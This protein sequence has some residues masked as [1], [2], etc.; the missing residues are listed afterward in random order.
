[1]RSLFL[2]SLVG[3]IHSSSALKILLTNEDGIEHQGLQILRKALIEKGHS[4]STFAPKKDM[5]GMGGALN[6]PTVHVEAYGEKDGDMW[7]VEGFPATTLLVGLA[8]MDHEPD[9]VSST[10]R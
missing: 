5:T 7:A 4:V 3:L 10:Q 9:L 8:K 6:M 2:L 1:M